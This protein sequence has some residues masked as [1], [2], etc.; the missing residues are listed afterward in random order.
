M[1]RQVA[2]YNWSEL[3]KEYFLG[4]YT[5]ITKFLK[6]KGMPENGHTRKMTNSWKSK[7]VIK[8]SEKSKKIIEKITERVIEKE[9]EKR[10]S[11]NSVADKLLEKIEQATNELG[12]VK[13]DDKVVTLP[14]DKSDIK[15]LT[16]ALKD[17]KE[18][19]EDRKDNPETSFASDIE[20]AWKDRNEK[21]SN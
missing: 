7:K 3:E 21:S 4:K 14:I 17:L 2:K 20:R 11:V 9:V 5:S 19:L 10:L 16:S 13:V 1:V 18:I 12:S 15:K 6:D 8:E